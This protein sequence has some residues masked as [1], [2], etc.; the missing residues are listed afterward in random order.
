MAE[1]MVGKAHAFA[2]RGT[3]I[4][5]VSGATYNART[6]L[7]SIRVGTNGEL[8]QIIG[9]T[10]DINALL[11]SGDFLEMTC[12][13][14]PEGATQVAAYLGCTIPKRGTGFNATSFGANQAG[15]ITNI[16][17]GPFENS[18]V[19]NSGSGV[20][21]TQPW[22]FISGEINAPNNNKWSMTWTLRRYPG[23]TVATSITA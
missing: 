2:L 9:Q 8:D 18:G 10:G 14:I 13:V 16:P 15:T 4:E 6:N 19:N 7:Q 11:F 20:T 12:E 5:T 17:I 3:L 22:I 1:T 23:I 21:D